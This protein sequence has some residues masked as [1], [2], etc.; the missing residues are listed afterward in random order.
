MTPYLNIKIILMNDFTQFIK[1]YLVVNTTTKEKY[2]YYQSCLLKIEKMGVQYV[3]C[4]EARNMKSLHIIKGEFHINKK[5]L[6][7]R[8]VAL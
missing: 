4:I 1:K 3:V 7:E 8:N 6:H 5:M 2:D